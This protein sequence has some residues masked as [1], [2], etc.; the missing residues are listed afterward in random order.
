[1]ESNQKQSE[2]IIKE[3][4]LESNKTLEEL[5]KKKNILKNSN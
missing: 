4:K 3:T 2:L 5:N 1:M